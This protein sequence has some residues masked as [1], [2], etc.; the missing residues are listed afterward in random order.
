MMFCCKVYIN[1]TI[2]QKHLNISN[3]TEYK[4]GGEMAE[5]LL[6]LPAII[7]GGVIGIVELLFIHSDEGAMGITWLAH[8]LHALPFT[9]LFV[10]ISMNVT[11]V[12]SL[13]NLSIASNFAVNLGVRIVVAV[14]AMIKIA[15]AAA[16]A[17]GARGVGE[18]IPHTLIIGALVLAAP[19]VWEFFLAALIGPLLPF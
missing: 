19:Y 4:K 13:L 9:M 2:K 1:L 6:I 11:F 18:K 16:I 7:M 8:G 12:F 3:R 15:G 17:P 10:F 14:I 5:E